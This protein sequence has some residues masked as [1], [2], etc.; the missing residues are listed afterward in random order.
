MLVGGWSKGP[1]FPVTGRRVVIM[2]DKEGVN[3]IIMDLD[4]NGKPLFSYPLDITSTRNGNIFVVDK[5]S[6][7]DIGRVVVLSQDGELLHLYTGSS[8]TNTKR[9]VLKP[10][11]IVATGAD[12][13]IFSD[14]Y[15]NTLHFLNNS[16]L[17]IM[18]FETG[19]MGIIFPMSMYFNTA[20][21]LYVGCSNSLSS[22]DNAKLF[23]LNI[24]EH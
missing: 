20:G 23:L 2:M 16:G 7:D 18:I 5:L 8:D 4:K 11:R 24:S 1:A 15:T 12:D 21:Q 9:G 19:D 6:N 22:L 3:E 17:L 10:V 14:M 13:V